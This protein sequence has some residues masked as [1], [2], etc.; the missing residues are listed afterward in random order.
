MA[1][2]RTH[3]LLGRM[4]LT[5]SGD[6][7]YVHLDQ[8][9]ND[10]DFIFLDY[11]DATTSSFT[12]ESTGACLSVTYPLVWLVLTLRSKPD[13]DCPGNDSETDFVSAVKSKVAAGGTVALGVG[14]SMD[15][16]TFAAKTSA[17][18]DHLVAGISDVVDAFG[19]NG[20]V[21]DCAAC[22]SD[23]PVAGYCDKVASLLKKLRNK[24]GSNFT[25]A[26]QH[27]LVQDFS[28]DNLLDTSCTCPSVFNLS[29]DNDTVVDLTFIDF[30]EWSDSFADL[31]GAIQYWNSSDGLAAVADLFIHG[32]PASTSA[33]AALPPQRLVI[34]T[35]GGIDVN[36][37]TRLAALQHA[38]SCITEGN[39]CNSYKPRDGPQPSFV[40]F[41]DR[42]YRI[43]DDELAQGKFRKAMKPFLA[44]LP[45][46]DSSTTT[47][48]SGSS[49]E[50]D[51]SSSTGGS[52]P[53]GAS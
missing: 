27:A 42:D 24:L 15:Q 49:T 41:L 29:A 23:V 37:D 44:G 17:D 6:T 20:A 3:P 40:G 1:L 13:T 21:V 51:A 45:G 7:P 52:N 53:K 46:G 26:V 22:S 4:W 25:L 16:K 43:N 18:L 8:V 30:A 33:P 38:M 35:A 11:A 9:S 36:A 31:Y 19:F 2:Q 28:S 5:A 50:S 10:W 39:D 12:F 14:T 34:G 48:L 32:L 47:T